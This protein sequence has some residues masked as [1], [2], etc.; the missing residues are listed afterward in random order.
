MIEQSQR[1]HH[2]RQLCSG[3]EGLIN[4]PTRKP[5]YSDKWIR[6]ANLNNWPANDSQLATAIL[7]GL[8]LIVLIV[9]A[10]RK[11]R[12]IR[13]EFAGL[14]FDIRRLSDE[15]RELRAAEQRRFLKEL[16]VSRRRTKISPSIAPESSV[17]A[18]PSPS[19][20]QVVK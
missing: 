13:K 4:P 2:L 11:V 12:V 5:R 15:V 1:R 18:S 19:S 10:F 14:K 16:K 20:L 8:I 6:E 7:F 3:W 17:S 9:A